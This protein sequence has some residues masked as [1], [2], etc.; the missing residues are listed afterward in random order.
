M[1]EAQQGPL[2]QYRLELA[3]RHDVVFSRAPERAL[4]AALYRVFEATAPTLAHITHE[5][6]VN[7]FTLSPLYTV[8]NDTPIRPALGQQERVWVRLTT[9]D[10]QISQAFQTALSIEN[11][12]AD[13]SLEYQPFAVTQ[14]SLLSP[15]NTTDLVAR[16]YEQ[17]W[18]AAEPTT[19][20][21]LRFYSPT[22]FRHKG[23]DLL[24]PTPA[25]VFG[26]YLKRWQ[27]F[28]P[29]PLPNITMQEIVDQVTVQATQ[30]VTVRRNLGYVRQPGFTGL[31]AY[32]L[33]GDVT[34][35]RIL[36][37]LAAF[38]HYCG[39]GARTAFGMGQTEVLPA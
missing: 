12:P 16:S 3:P 20:I 34:F 15:A 39:T 5:A 29:C 10:R 11:R 23:V 22:V 19:S 14:F 37:T 17:L 7:P 35:Q 2:M 33:S 21:T 6:A 28:S 31:A 26:S 9:L 30:L 27:A 13:L 1:W 25:L 24:F 8:A 38:A 4:H 32:R 18:A 36:A